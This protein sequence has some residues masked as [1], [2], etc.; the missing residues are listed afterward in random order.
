[1]V[2]LVWLGLVAAV[3]CAAAQHHC[4]QMPSS[5]TSL[6][7]VKLSVEPTDE[8]LSSLTGI[9]KA[10]KQSS[11]SNAIPQNFP[12]PAFLNI[13]ELKSRSQ[14]GTA[15]HLVQDDSKQIQMPSVRQALAPGHQKG[16][17][18]E[19]TNKERK[20]E[21]E[22]KKEQHARDEIMARAEVWTVPPISQAPSRQTWV[23]CAIAFVGLLAISLF[24]WRSHRL[25][26]RSKMLSGD[27]GRSCLIDNAKV[28]A[29]FC[30]VL[31]HLILYGA[32]KG[33]S[34]DSRTWLRGAQDVA[35]PVMDSIR[36]VNMPLF[37]FISGVCSQGP[38]STKRVRT[39]F[40]RLVCPALMCAI[41]VQPIFI[42]LLELH[43]AEAWQNLKS[44]SCFKCP[45]YFHALIVWRG[46]ILVSASWVDSRIMCILFVVWSCCG[47][48]FD[49]N[50]DYLSLDLN[51]TTGYAAYFGIGYAFPF[52]E[53][54]NLF[55]EH[56]SEEHTGLCFFCRHV[57]LAIAWAVCLLLWFNSII[58]T[59][60]ME[61]LPNPH[62]NYT[63]TFQEPVWDVRL[64]WT[65]RL[66]RIAVDMLATLSL[67]FG[68]LPRSKTCYTWMGQHTIYVYVFSPIAGAYKGYV[69][70]L[71]NAPKVWPVAVFLFYVLYAIAQLAFFASLPW[72]RFFKW[73]F[74]PHWLDCLMG[75]AKADAA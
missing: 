36:M 25:G 27:D 7:Q 53:V 60:F 71:M 13:S 74:E 59:H 34:P 30:V 6:L 48:Y 9:S 50:L 29:M 55:A 19:K 61:R 51:V 16:G 58:T 70:Q 44:F 21:L 56:G 69:V 37:C 11:E 67:T 24:A 43:P 23:C 15:A 64:F 2:R 46:I 57:L 20:K 52:K 40:T 3:A 39:H 66:A 75:N 14:I 35:L 22:R 33:H 17:T 41:L 47:G 63:I 68:I 32:L 31:G 49:L 18:P 5:V 8:V 28:V 73:C 72:R 38:V 4:E 45:W 42:P 26:T 54:C 1:M 65:R 10:R 12:H 62:G